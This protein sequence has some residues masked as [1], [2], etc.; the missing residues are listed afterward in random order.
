VTRLR[1]AAVMPLR[2]IAVITVT[3]GILVRAAPAAD[4]PSVA[5]T[6]VVESPVRISPSG[7]GPHS[8]W[9]L[10]ASPDDPSRIVA[11]SQ[12]TP[13]QGTMLR[14]VMYG[15][16][17]GGA[18]WRTLYTD[19]SAGRISE[20]ACALGRGDTAYLT[21]SE[22][23]LTFWTAL[24][25][26]DLDYKILQDMVL[27]RSTD[28][29]RTWPM[30]TRG[31]YADAAVTLVSPGATADRDAVVVFN[32]VGPKSPGGQV[33]G[34]T[35]GGRTFPAGVRDLPDIPGN[36]DR[37]G[38]LQQAT[39]LPD[40]TLGAMYM[41]PEGGPVWFDRAT[42]DGRPIGKPAVIATLRVDADSIL[43]RHGRYISRFR[44]G[45]I[46]AG[47]VP[48][49][50]RARVYAAWPDR[51]GERTRVRLATS[52]DNGLTWSEPRVV[53]DSADRPERERDSQASH[54]S[55]AINA[56]GVVGLQWM[57]F[58]GLCWR[59]AASR[60]GGKS[61]LPSAAL[62]PCAAAQPAIGGNMGVYLYPQIDRDPGTRHLQISLSHIGSIWEVTRGTA[63]AAAADGAF[64]AGWVAFDG[65]E[66]AIYTNRITVGGDDPRV[67]R[68]RAILQGIGSD[69]LAQTVDQTAV[70]DFTHSEYDERT[71]VFTIETVVVRRGVEPPVW[72]VVLM[73][74]KLST[75]LGS[76]T[77]VGAD[78]GESAEGAAWVFDGPAE[79]LPAGSAAEIDR[80]T[81]TRE[82][83]DY[84]RPRSLRFRLADGEKLSGYPDPAL[85][86]VLNVDCEILLP[87]ADPQRQS[88]QTP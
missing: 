7:T 77:V 68:R 75:P 29:G 57:E 15:S 82:K 41:S 61:F 54:P 35:D 60:D 24:E 22:Q 74:R 69:R 16:R 51:V 13:P 42:A 86:K 28:F 2:R 30:V 58:E 36:G 12:F 63:L 5:G 31:L 65:G 10:A 17:D 18:T 84:S 76:L 52:D 14:A 78:N 46:A 71:R 27:R 72:P 20:V 19:S 83:F 66:G 23:G 64:H 45:S 32:D 62:N 47:T 49:T 85:W 50:S 44:Y 56:A 53:D 39:R 11:C 4:R 88:H 48:G 55:L 70:L 87:T 37:F 33:R 8:W 73:M 79:D 80:T 34:S 81:P 67:S 21:T 1:R 43:E 40:G 38:F 3:V 6:I 26:A 9:M 25:R 59:F